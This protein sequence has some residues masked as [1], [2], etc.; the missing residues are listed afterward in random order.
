MNKK[1]KIRAKL[2]DTNGTKYILIPKRE[3][4]FSK[5]TTDDILDVEITCEVL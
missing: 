1:I 4:E 3:I 2:K 5:I